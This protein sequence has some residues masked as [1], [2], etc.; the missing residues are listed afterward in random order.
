MIIVIENRNIVNLINRINYVDVQYSWPTEIKH[1]N[2]FCFC[3]Y[4][5]ALHMTKARGVIKTTI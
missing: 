3:F 4:D 2:V 5:A 1:E